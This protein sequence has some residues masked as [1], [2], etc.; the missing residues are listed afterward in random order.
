MSQ[1]SFT[2]I[3]GHLLLDAAGQLDQPGPG[4]STESV[5]DERNPVQ[6]L[7]HLL[8]T[9]AH[10]NRA[11]QD[12]EQHQGHEHDDKNRAVSQGD[13]VGGEV[14]QAERA[15]VVF[16]QAS[17]KMS[18]RGRTSHLRTTSLD[19]ELPQDWPRSR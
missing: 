4:E 9:P 5:G 1:K 6:P 15:A 16:H 7:A 8:H 11:E 2:C 12:A 10:G 3:S 14:R 19:T 13:R 17:P 18:P